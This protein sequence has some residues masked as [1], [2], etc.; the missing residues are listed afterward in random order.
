M[1]DRVEILHKGRKLLRIILSH[2]D[3]S[4]IADLTRLRL[5]ELG[6]RSLPSRHHCRLREVILDHGQEL[7]DVGLKTSIIEINIFSL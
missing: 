5:K 7:S 2:I 6:A 3:K 1:L 4:S